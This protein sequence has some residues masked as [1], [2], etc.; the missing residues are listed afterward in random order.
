LFG[1]FVFGGGLE[2]LQLVEGAVEGALDAGFVAAQ[3]SKGV[4]AADVAQV[5]KSETSARG[6]VLVLRLELPGVIVGAELE[7][8]AFDEAEAFETPGGHDNALDEKG[9]DGADGL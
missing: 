1:Q 8:A 7:D 3:E 2:A 9:L 6:H 4:G 5:E